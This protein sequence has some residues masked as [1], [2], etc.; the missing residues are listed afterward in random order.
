MVLLLVGGVVAM[1]AIG[2]VI[3][4]QTLPPPPVPLSLPPNV[5]P[6]PPPSLPLGVN[7]VSP[8]NS[9]LE[10]D[11]G[12]DEYDIVA[13]GSC[14]AMVEVILYDNFDYE[15]PN[16]K[17]I[18]T[19]DRG[20]VDTILPLA[21][22]TNESGEID[23]NVVSQTVGTSTLGV[24]VDGIIFPQKLQLHVLDPVENDC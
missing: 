20:S 17:V 19:S 6:P 15:M 24:S 7:W 23:F 21:L 11:D 10:F 14:A 12:A 9:T 1:A 16:K 22:V 3:Y 8:E 18:L 5:L 13:S 4:F 2:G